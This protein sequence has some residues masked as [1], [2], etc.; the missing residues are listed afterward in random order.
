[1]HDSEGGQSAG[2]VRSSVPIKKA[3]VD[4]GLF[5]YN[6]GHEDFAFGTAY[7]TNKEKEIINYLDNLTDVSEPCREV[8]ASSRITNIPI[9]LYS[10]KMDYN[11]LWSKGVDKPILHI[12]PFTIYNTD[13]QSLGKG[14]TIKFT[15]DGIDFISFFTSN[16]MKERLYMNMD[17]KVKLE[18][19]LTCELGWNIWNGRKS[20]QAII[21]DFECRKVD[22]EIL[23]FDDIW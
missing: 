23:S 14:N 3:L 11:E 5:D 20:K 1:M 16:E 7:Q 6:D 18:V 2:S 8:L 4:S 10:L 12:Q 9:D 21:Q 22:E 17:E 19:E 13:I 15:K